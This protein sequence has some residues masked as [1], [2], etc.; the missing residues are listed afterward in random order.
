MNEERI[1]VENRKAR[2]DY[3]IE[4][5]LEAGLVL[6]GSEVKS[7]R[8]ARV[9]LKEAYVKVRRGEAWLVGCHIAEYAQAG[10][11]QN[12]EPLR[13]R[14]LLLHRRELKRLIG[15]VE[16]SGYTLVP[17]RLH[18]KGPRVKLLVGLARGKRKADKREAIK[19]RDMEREAE[20]AIRDRHR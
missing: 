5:T 17:L 7:L 19:R 8:Q 1:I 13:R 9:Q 3:F 4:E 11:H 14:K 18:F 6:L 2:R 10:P 12:H 20:R 15:L 16:R